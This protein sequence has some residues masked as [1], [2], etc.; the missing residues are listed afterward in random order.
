MMERYLEVDDE[1]KRT[2]GYLPDDESLDSQTIARMESSLSAA[3]I[4]VQNSIG[5]NDKYYQDEDNKSLYKIAC[6]SIASNWFNHPS[7][8]S[9]STVA[10]AVIGQMRGVFDNYEEMNNGSTSE[11]GQTNADD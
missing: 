3:E 2:L 10:K 8:A 1:F 4:F 11:F 9:S 5:K 7:T 6:Y